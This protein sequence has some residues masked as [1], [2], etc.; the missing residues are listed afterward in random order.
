MKRFLSIAALLF[1]TLSAGSF[2]PLKANAQDL[3]GARGLDPIGLYTFFN[4]LQSEAMKEGEP[5]EQKLAPV[6]TALDVASD[7]TTGKTIFYVGGDAPNL[8]YRNVKDVERLVKGVA[9]PKEEGKGKYG[10]VPTTKNMAQ[11]DDWIRAIAVNPATAEV[12]TLTQRGQ[13][14]IW[15]P[16]CSEQVKVFEAKGINGAHAMKF[17]PNGKILAVCGFNN[18][19]RFYGYLKEGAS[20]TGSDFEEID[21]AWPLSSRSCTT[22]DFYSD[23]DPATGLCTSTLLAVG[24]R[25]T[26]EIWDVVNGAS[27]GEFRLTNQNGGVPRRVRAVAFSPDVKRLAV[28]GDA[29]QIQIWDV[30]SNK[31]VSSVSLSNRGAQNQGGVSRRIFSMAFIDNNTLAT[32]D[33]VNDV[34]IWDVASGRATRQGKG[35]KQNETKSDRI[36]HSGTVASLVYVE[37]AKD[38]EAPRSLLT[39]GFDT[40]VIRWKLP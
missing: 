4:T 15:D 31:L 32:G 26:A 29:D 9:V 5:E 7:P 19:L 28:A 38:D 16:S 39:G 24:G 3:S 18:N 37:N 33:S 34:I 1:A 30:A 13:V 22:L 21:A 8:Y 11:V 36:A 6:I 20:F 2:V 40:L 10:V 23:R 12:A 35:L 17:S 27:L 25:E 14:V